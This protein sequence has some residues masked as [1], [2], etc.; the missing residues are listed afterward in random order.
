MREELRKPVYGGF[1][2]GTKAVCVSLGGVACLLSLFLVLMVG[3][4]FLSSLFQEESGGTQGIGFFS[5][6]MFSEVAFLILIAC[7]SFP[8][9]RRFKE[10]CSDQT[11]KMAVILGITVWCFFNPI[12]D[13]LAKNPSYLTLRR[14]F[15]L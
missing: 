8:L 2:Y 10:V 5:G 9:L 7:L 14:K 15:H 6:L 1:Y 3:W 13:L 4:V 11:F 12:F